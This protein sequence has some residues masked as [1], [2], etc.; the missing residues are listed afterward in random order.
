MLLNDPN[1]NIKKIADAL[2]C[3]AVLGFMAVVALICIVFALLN[4]AERLPQ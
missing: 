1:R 4:V 2:G 3:L